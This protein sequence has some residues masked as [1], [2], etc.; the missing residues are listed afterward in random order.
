[1]ERTITLESLNEKLD[2]LTMINSIGVKNNL[3]IEEA[4]VYTGLTVAY[5]YK[6]T[7]QKR[8]PYRKP[9]GTKLLYFNKEDLD[10]WIE[11]NRITTDAEISGKAATYVAT[12]R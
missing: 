3:R 12:H 1:M 2:R 6:L 7:C 9:E 10:R 4:A 8:I 5:I 11:K